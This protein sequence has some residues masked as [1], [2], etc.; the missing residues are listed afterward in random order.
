MKVGTITAVH[1]LCSGGARHCGDHH[2]IVANWSSI[3]TQMF[4]GIPEIARRPGRYRQQQ[5][6]AKEGREHYVHL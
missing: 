6:P 3:T 1:D 4:K 2:P 5:T